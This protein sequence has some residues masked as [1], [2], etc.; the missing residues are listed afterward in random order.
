MLLSESTQKLH[1]LLATR[2][3]LRGKIGNYTAK[4]RV[5]HILFSRK[6]N[7]PLIIP[8]NKHAFS[9]SDIS[10]EALSVIE[11]LQTAGFEAYLVGGSIRDALLGCK[12]KDFDI[13]TNATPE[14]V[15]IVFRKAR[16]IG[17]RFRI[18]HVRFGREIIEVTTFRGQTQDNQQQQE[19]ATG[20]LIRDNAYGDMQS[21]ALRRDFTA[22]AL[23][24]SPQDEAITDYTQGIEDINNRQLRM[25]GDPLTRY[26][27]DPVR[28]LRA[29][30]FAA[31][32]G[33]TIEEQT[34]APIASN[35]NLLQHVAPAR[36]FDEVLKIFLNGSATASYTLLKEFKLLAPLF[37]ET[38]QVIDQ[39]PYFDALISEVM[40]NT[41]KRIRNNKRVTPAFIYAAFLWPAFIAEQHRLNN[42]K[43]PIMAAI[44]QA[45]DSVIS[46]QVNIIA[47]PKRFSVPMKQI[48]ELQW[49]LSL[50]SQKHADKTLKHEKFR[51]GY[52]FLLMREASGA[53]LNGLGQWWTQYQDLPVEKRKDMIDKLTPPNHQSR[54]PRK[55]KAAGL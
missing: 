2:L 19:S 15:K 44:H 39:S 10:R 52:D 51:A 28:L 17:R 9:R 21:D 22:N 30:R 20:Q 24:Y 55:R 42:N 6:A 4:H 48:W 16:I 38:A 7:K 14:Q 32:L 47:I 54:K 34:A 46:K 12:P 35:G 29:V 36:L 11:N 25:I 50:R 26:K 27:E 8:N 18:V 37:P 40:N 43:I 33:F 1:N 3:G 41:D 23:Y 13:A 49:R 53:R 31:K 5:L 45:A